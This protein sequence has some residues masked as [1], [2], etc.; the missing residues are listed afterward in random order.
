MVVLLLGSEKDRQWAQKITGVLQ[1]FGVSHHTHIASAHKT[2]EYLLEIVRKYEKQ[3]KPLVYIC[4]AGGSN[5]LGG[6]VDAHVVHPV[7]NCPP[8][9]E[10]YAGLDI[11]SSL[12]MPSGVS[13]VTVLEPEQAAL[14][15]SKMLALGSAELTKKV[16]KYQKRIKKKIVGSQ[17]ALG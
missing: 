16:T 17:K 13:P 2:P 11:L 15:A 6:F 12:R 7:I 3:N 4:I 9:S 10:K 14:A 1:E 8:Y 5:A